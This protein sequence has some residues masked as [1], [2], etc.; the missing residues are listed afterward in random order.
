M[1][2]KE[3]LFHL[4]TEQG[5]FNALKSQRQPGHPVTAPEIR[6]VINETLCIYTPLYLPAISIWQ[7]ALLVHYSITC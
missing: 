4:S 2:D 6:T 5:R 3:C 1:S 7:T